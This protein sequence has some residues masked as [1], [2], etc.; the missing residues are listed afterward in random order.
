LVISK[1]VFILRGTVFDK[2]NWPAWT[3]LRS[4]IFA[5]PFTG[6]PPEADYPNPTGEVAEMQIV[7]INERMCRTMCCCSNPGDGDDESINISAL[8]I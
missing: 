2:C 1:C 4:W 7:K 3:C 5:I 8:P 6:R